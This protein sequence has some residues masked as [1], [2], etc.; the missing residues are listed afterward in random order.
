MMAVLNTKVVDG[1]IPLN[2]VLSETKE[3]VKVVLKLCC[4][5]AGFDAATII[6]RLD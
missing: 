4:A 1:R 5:F 2:L 6:R 3:N